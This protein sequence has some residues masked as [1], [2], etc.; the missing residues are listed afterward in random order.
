LVYGPAQSA[1]AKAVVDSVT[2][3]TIS[4]EDADDLIII[5]NVFVHPTAIDRQRVYVNNYKAM[6]HAIR[7]AM[8]GRPDMDELIEN[9]ERS[10]HPLRY[11]P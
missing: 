1:V 7:K 10:K 2:D 11:T 8:E 5:A 9:K 6:R 3:G 4:R